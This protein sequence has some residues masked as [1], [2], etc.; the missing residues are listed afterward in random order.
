MYLD[1]TKG[2]DT[3]KV[4]SR[5]SHYT[6]LLEDKPFRENPWTNMDKALH[7]YF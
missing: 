2:R 5:L 7:G 6:M 1:G 3:G 4:S